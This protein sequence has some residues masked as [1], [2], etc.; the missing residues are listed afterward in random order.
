MQ[1]IGQLVKYGLIDVLMAPNSIPVALRPVVENL[2]N[3]SFFMGRPLESQTQ[4]KL[5]ANLR[6][7]S[8]TSD[9]MKGL[10]DVLFAMGIPYSP[11]KLEN[12]FRG[13]LG[14]TAGLTLGMADAMVNPTRTDRPLHKDLLAQ[15]SGASTFMKDAIGKR[16]IDELYTL[17]EKTS[18]AEAS[19]KKLVEEDPEKADA[20]YDENFALIAYS[21]II[22]K[23]LDEL[24]KLRKEVEMLDKQEGVPPDERRRQIDEVLM[25]QNEVAQDVFA[26][27][28]E[29]NQL[30]AEGM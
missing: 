8:S 28:N 13:I 5:D 29:I 27:R 25:I 22:K 10:S 7:N 16:Q 18:A 3:H 6:F 9:S 21:P 30:K 26:I 23:K 17:N 24:S 11:I 4:Q 2:T 20:Y 14:T 15:M 19:Y 12:L 1:I